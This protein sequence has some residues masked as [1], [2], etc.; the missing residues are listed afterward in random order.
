MS[1]EI[2][3]LGV[4][5]T[6]ASI[7]AG[8]YKCS[9]VVQAAIDRLRDVN[10]SL[11][12]VTVDL[13]EEAL[14]RA[15]ELDQKSQINDKIGPLF[16]VPVTLKENIDLKG[17]ATT[18]AVEG[19][20]KN[21]AP[22]DAPVVDFLKQ[23]GSIIIGQTNMPEFGLR[24]LTENPMRGRTNNPW[25]KTLTPGGSSGGAAA[26]VAMGIGSLA[27]GNDIGGSLR[28]PSYC[29]GLVTIKPSFGSVPNYNPSMGVKRPISFQIMAVQGPI[30]RSVADTKLAFEVMSKGSVLDPW[31]GESTR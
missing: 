20:A 14:E 2:W 25:D 24:W 29:C 3:K 7:R 12:A 27:H 11:N 28:Y 18:L 9:E 31:S 10:P 6:A 23:S 16:G 5:E 1:D 22:A 19:F 26:A 4:C 13:S 30:T 8:E 17:K 21:I 15:H